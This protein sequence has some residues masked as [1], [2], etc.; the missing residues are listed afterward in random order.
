MN[1]AGI[2]NFLKI[3]LLF[4]ILFTPFIQAKE[5][6]YKVISE[7]YL[8]PGDRTRSMVVKEKETIDNLLLNK[9]INE[10]AAVN[11]DT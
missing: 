5:L 4:F 11:F 10:D 1:R 9:S 7:G 2:F 8:E 3:F 6:S